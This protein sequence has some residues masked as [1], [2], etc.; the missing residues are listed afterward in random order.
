MRWWDGSSWTEHVKAPEAQEPLVAGTLPSSALFDLQAKVDEKL[1]E[2]ISL[3]QQ[4]DMLKSAVVETRD[5][6]LLQEVGIYRYSHPLDNSAQY[7]DALIAVESAM[8]EC[9]KRGTAVTGAKRWVIN[10]SEKD[11]ARMISD[12]SK[13]ML[14]A[15]NN[16]VDTLVRTLKAYA[17]DSALARLEKMRSS[18]AKLTAS[19]KIE[20]TDEFHNLRIKELSLTADYQAKL[21]EEKE[22][23]REE[24]ARL[25]EEETARKEFEREQARLEKER[26]HYEQAIKAFYAKGDATAAAAASEKL[27]QIQHAIDGVVSRAA[28]IRAGYVYVISNIGSFGDCVVKIGLTRRLEPLDR[29]RELGD[30]SVPFRFDV[31]ALVFSDDAVSLETQLHQ[32]FL[33]RRVNLVN[34]HREFFYA[35]PVEVKRALLRLRGDLVTYVEEPEALEW[36]QSESSRKAGPNRQPA[37]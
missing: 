12:L 21:A 5:V 6:V 19:M 18:V 9:V 14:R 29:V 23:E 36:H 28:N 13:L 2:L 1:R 35:N 16:E 30:A 34:A 26:T 8:K 7:R 37:P 4:C 33:D 3:Q 20:I 11:G 27:E 22:R 15:Y 17:L 25:K 31:H 24:R 10:G 32:E